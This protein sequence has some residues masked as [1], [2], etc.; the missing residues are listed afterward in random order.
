MNN[1]FTQEQIDEIRERLKNTLGA[2]DTQFELANLPLKGNEQIALVQDGVNKRVSIDEFYQSLSDFGL[3]D[4]FNV[5]HYVVRITESYEGFRMTLEGAINTCPP[6]VHRGGQTITFMG[7]DYEWHIWQYIGDTPD[8]WLDIENYWIDL[9][10]ARRVMEDKPLVA[11]V[12][13]GTWSY[14]N[15]GYSTNQKHIEIERGYTATWQ[16]TYSWNKQDGYKSPERAS[17]IFDEELPPSGINS[18]Q[19]TK[20]T[21]TNLSLSQSLFAEKVGL[22][23]KGEKVVNA[24]GE[25]S[26][27][28][29]VSVVFKDRIFYGVV[30]SPNP[31]ISEIKALANEL[32]S[33]RAKTIS[34]ITTP[35]G[36]YYLYAYPKSLGDLSSIIQDGA[37]PVLT[38]FNKQEITYTGQAGNSIVL[39]VYVSGNDGAFTNVKLQFS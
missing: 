3:V 7:E 9:L 36:K 24:I 20:S 39:N 21:T 26:T 6:D 30:S 12:L 5:S 18:S 31:S 33:S 38:A 28:D 14:G 1:L 8:N 32:V 15:V 37:T 23:V 35:K 16:G 27:M 29:S 4:F 10:V 19:V 22:I 17:G 34:G 2:K 13:N 11:P 25:D